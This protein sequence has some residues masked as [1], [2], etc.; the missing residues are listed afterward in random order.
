MTNHPPDHTRP[1]PYP[2]ISGQAPELP[3]TYAWQ[4]IGLGMMLGLAIAVLLFRLIV[5]HP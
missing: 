5:W 4:L 3:L 2:R 1:E